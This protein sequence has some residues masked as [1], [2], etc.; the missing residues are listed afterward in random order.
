MNLYGFASGDPVNF[1]DPFGLCP[2][3]LIGVRGFL[4]N[5]IEVLSIAAGA[6]LG[7]IGGGGAG[8][9]TGPGAIAATP[10]GAYAGAAAGAG[11]GAIAGRALTNYL[12]A[13]NPAGRSKNQP[14]YKE[15]VSGATGKEAASDVPSWAKGNRPYVG[16]SGKDFARRL[17]DQNYG[18]GAWGGTGP[19]SEF[20]KIKKWG[21]RGFVNPK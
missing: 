11:I 6:D 15:P 7:A 20:N 19:G 13:D 4:C 17:L 9:L 5:T 1:A 18:K 3:D 8:L 21:D 10:V 16:E 2:I 12:F 14:Q